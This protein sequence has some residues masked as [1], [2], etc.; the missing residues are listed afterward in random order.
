MAPEL[1]EDGK[2]YAEG[3]VYAF[4]II[5][6]EIY[7]GLTPYGTM[8]H[9]QVRGPQVEGARWCRYPPS[10][11]GNY[12][13]MYVSWGAKCNDVY[14]VSNTTWCRA[15][16]RVSRLWPACSFFCMLL[17]QLVGGCSFRSKWPFVSITTATGTDSMYPVAPLTW[18]AT[19]H[20]H[21]VAVA[22]IPPA[23]PLC[24]LWWAW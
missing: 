11:L 8:A 2:V 5:M 19:C 4:G 3:D 23:P 10:G 21:P 18:H 20:A 16:P 6:Y 7:S 14:E 22:L 15:S 9:P 17:P 24:R 12:A 13:C 1:I